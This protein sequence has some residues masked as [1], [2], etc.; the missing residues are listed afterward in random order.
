MSHRL[1]IR[2]A[3]AVAGVALLGLTACGTE[4]SPSTTVTPSG[5]GLDCSLANLSLRTPGTLTIGTDSPAYPPYFVDDDPSNG[6]G[7]ESAVAYALAQNLG[8]TKEQVKWVV[9]PF[10]SS[11]APGAKTFDFDI[12]QI[13][14]T[15][16]RLKAVDFSDGYYAVQQAVI[17][18]KGTPGAA[19]TSIADLQ[20]LKLGAQVGTTSLKYVQDIVRPTA[21]PSVYDDTNAATQALKN[22][23]IDAIV[24]DLPT[25]FYITGVELDNGA[26][27]GAFAA[28]QGGE[29]FG[30]LFEKG[31][32]LV[33]CVNNA[34][35][36]L[37]SQGTLQQITDQWLG[38]E[39]GVPTLS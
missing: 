7:F 35:G 8:F 20:A 15:P 1:P 21:S 26:I 11:Y 24:V 32:G 13:S 37:R 36:L 23:N 5:S 27:V 17:A 18:I 19:A 39:A 28:G 12:N 2:T 10:N 22:G 6:K 25:A 9:V 14:I 29:E 30:L 16:E 34:L 3:V 33:P 4:E 31:S 38:G